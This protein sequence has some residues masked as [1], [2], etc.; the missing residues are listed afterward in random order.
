MPM[1][2]MMLGFNIV[3]QPLPG[4]DTAAKQ[5]VLQDKVTGETWV[6]PMSGELC[7]DIARQLTAKVI[8][9]PGNGH[10]PSGLPPGVDRAIAKAL[11]NPKGGQG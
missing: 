7:R 4:D 6:L 5:L 1:Q 11:K 8:I 3:A 10:D 2:H 9:Q